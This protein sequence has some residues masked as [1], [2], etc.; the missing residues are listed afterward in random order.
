[1]SEQLMGYVPPSEASEEVPAGEYLTLAQAAKRY[2]QRVASATV[3]RHCRHGVKTRG[4]GRI[5]L[6]HIRQGGKLYTR[7][8]WL[9]EFFEAV[10]EADREHFDAQREQPAP[11]ASTGRRSRTAEQ[12]EREIRQ[13]EEACERAGA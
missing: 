6:R 13:A 2:V 3:W 9:R 1:M 8:D 12:R 10:A 7:E 11:P 4:G 5:H